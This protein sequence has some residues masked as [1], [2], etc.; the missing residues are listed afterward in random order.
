MLLELI[1]TNPAEE[2]SNYL[3]VESRDNGLMRE[4]SRNINDDMVRAIFRDVATKIESPHSTVFT[5]KEQYENFA[6]GHINQLTVFAL[7]SPSIF[8]GF[9]SVNVLA[10]NVE[11]SN[12]LRY[13]KKQTIQPVQFH[14]GNKLL[15]QLRYAVHPNGDTLDI[16]YALE[17]PWSKTIRD[18]VITPNQPIRTVQEWAEFMAADTLKNCPFVYMVNKDFEAKLF[19]HERVVH[20]LGDGRREQLPNTTHGLNQYQSFNNVAVFSALNPPPS[21]YRFL[22]EIAGIDPDEVKA[23]GM[24]QSVYQAAMRISLRNPDNRDAKRV[25]VMDK[26]TAEFLQKLCHGSRTHKLNTIDLD[27]AIDAA[28]KKEGR[29]KKWANE[30]EKRAANAQRMRAKRAAKKLKK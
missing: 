29:P 2:N 10:A 14:R 3:V 28:T 17:R 4:F 24:R 12:M 6:A 13:W 26:P 1:T 9:G 30:A 16:Y 15:S 5:L 20:I 21:H 27:A 25:V 22:A 11:D 8:D 18:K 23:A 7:I 19:S